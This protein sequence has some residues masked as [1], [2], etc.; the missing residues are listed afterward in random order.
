MKSLYIMGTPASGKTALALGLAQKLQK[1][2][3]RVAYFKPVGNP[4]RGAGGVDE[5]AVLMREVLRME[6]PLEVMV[7]H[8]ADPSYLLG[9]KPQEA[10]AKVQQAYEQI[11][12]GA[13]IVLIGGA[14]YPYAYASYGMDDITLA[15]R[16]NAQVL[17]VINIENDFSLDQA[18]FFNRSLTATGAKI[19]GNI[20]NNVPRPL[21]AKTEGIYRPILVLQRRVE[22]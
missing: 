17:L 1:E 21:W 9:E 12:A 3:F 4:T 15:S 22:I 5:D 2:G 18:L 8:A 16:F 13:E 11:A 6:V 10:L 20:F 14:V 19:L 7:P